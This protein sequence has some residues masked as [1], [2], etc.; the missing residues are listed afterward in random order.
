MLAINRVRLPYLKDETKDSKDLKPG[1]EIL[2][3]EKV[4]LKKKDF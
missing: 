1:E 4:D 3:E 2:E